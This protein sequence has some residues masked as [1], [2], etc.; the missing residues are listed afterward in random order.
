MRPINELFQEVL[1][2][3]A[4]RAAPGVEDEMVRLVEG[5]CRAAVEAACPDCAVTAGAGKGVIAHVPW[6]AIFRP[7]VRVSVQR[8]IYL[9]YLFAY[10]GSAVYLSLNQG[11]EHAPM[12]M[13]RARAQAMRDLLG[14]EPDLLTDIDLVSDSGRPTRYRVGN[15]YAIPYQAGSLPTESEMKADLERMLEFISR[16]PGTAQELD[17]LAPSPAEPTEAQLT[18]SV[19]ADEGPVELEQ[20]GDD[21]EEEALGGEAWIE[22]EAVAMTARTFSSADP[23]PG[24]EWEAAMESLLA[25]IRASGL[26]F[27]PWQV[28]AF[29]TALRTKPFVILAGISGTGKTRLPR[30]VAEACG[31]DHKTIPVRPDWTDSS[32]LLGYRDLKGEFRP[33]I[34]LRMAAAAEGNPGRTHIAVLDEMNLARAEHYFAEVLSRIEERRIRNGQWECDPLLEAADGLDLADASGWGSVALAPNLAIVGTVN[35]DESS[36]GFSRK[37]LDRAFTLELSEVFLSNWR[38]GRR[39]SVTKSDPWP[40]AALTPR[41]TSLTD[42]DGLSADDERLIESVVEALKALNRSL[43][44]AQLQVGYRARDEAALFVLN[45]RDVENAFIT[46]G[47]ESV[48]PLDLAVTMKILPR[49]IGGSGA[50]RQVLCGVLG[51]ATGKNNVDENEADDLVDEWH[52][53]G[54]PGS[55]P[56]YPYPRSAARLCLMWERLREDGF[57]SFWL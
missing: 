41:A 11:T 44:I 16:L 6:V 53:A 57:T 42:L 39:A 40:A 54:R 47:G 10:D 23:P 24:W 4:N 35:M 20:G 46:E 38:V 15:A 8:G 31:M 7:G 9:V 55:L 43:Q 21:A 37:V 32:D 48:A 12:S 33:G 36:H 2:L 5:Q 34:L 52:R 14:P 27:E 51:W 26:F 22:K 17:E 19:P 56:D 50:S 18:I 13:I 45:A 29:I 49:I 1:D 28:A 25:Y 30:I 3:L